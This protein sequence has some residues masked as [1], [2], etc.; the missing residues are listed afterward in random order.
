MARR[1]RERHR[2]QVE[3]QRVRSV[4]GPLCGVNRLSVRFSIDPEKPANQVK[5]QFENNQQTMLPV[6]SWNRKI[7]ILPESGQATWSI[8]PPG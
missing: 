7:V 8:H 2:T 1:S 3:I 6:G 5:S 4:A